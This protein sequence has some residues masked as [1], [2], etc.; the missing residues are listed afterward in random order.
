MEDFDKNDPFVN[1]SEVS[2]EIEYEDDGFPSSEEE[3]TPSL[4]V[5][6]NAGFGSR[7]YECYIK[8]DSTMVIPDPLVRELDLHPGDE[9]EYDYDEEEKVLYISKKEIP[10]ESPEWMQD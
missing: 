2:D 6:V 9:L 5:W 10:W 4:M 8:S 1:E 3:T 7:S